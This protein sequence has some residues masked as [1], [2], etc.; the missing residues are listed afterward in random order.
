MYLCV[1][2]CACVCQSLDVYESKQQLSSIVDTTEGS[3]CR[4]HS[5]N[6]RAEL[7]INVFFSH[8]SFNQLFINTPCNT[9]TQG[10]SCQSHTQ[11]TK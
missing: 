7:N 9:G 10:L 1:C 8:E 5:N 4:F 11:P 2:L 6:A 3:L